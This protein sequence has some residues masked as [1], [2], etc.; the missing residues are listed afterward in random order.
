M[1]QQQHQVI[2]AIYELNDIIANSDVDLANV[3]RAGREQRIRVVVNSHSEGV[4]GLGLKGKNDLKSCFV[5]VRLGDFAI[6]H[7]Q[8]LANKGLLNQADFDWLRKQQRPCMVNDCLALVPNLGDGWQARLFGSV[9]S[10]PDLPPATSEPTATESFTLPTAPPVHG[11]ELTGSSP[12]PT[13]I[14]PPAPPEPPADRE[15]ELLAKFSEFKTLG[16]NKA[17]ICFA[18]WQAKKGGTDRYKMASD[19]YERLNSKYLENNGGNAA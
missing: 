8:L 14:A 18:M 19:F 1:A 13:P 4:E 9:P 3:A 2:V 7:A 6:R 12:E 11:S 16:M 15:A 5:W 10:Q 17:Q